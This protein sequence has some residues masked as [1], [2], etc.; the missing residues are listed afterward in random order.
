MAAAR[1]RNLH[2]AH[3]LAGHFHDPEIDR[4]EPRHLAATNAG[5]APRE[6]T[7]NGERFRMSILNY[8]PVNG[9]VG[10]TCDRPDS[11]FAVSS[12]V[13]ACRSGYRA[14]PR[15]HLLERPEPDGMVDLTPSTGPR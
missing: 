8:F 13:R 9:P 14:K 5:S 4:A 10:R 15:R 2:A 7:A 6:A 1:G 3:E 12:M 11:A